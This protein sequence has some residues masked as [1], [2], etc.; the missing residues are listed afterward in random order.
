LITNVRTFVSLFDAVA[1]HH[2]ELFGGAEFMPGKGHCVHVLRR[3][4][5][6][7][8]GGD[9]S[10]ARKT[11]GPCRSRVMDRFDKSHSDGTYRIMRAEHVRWSW[12]AP[13]WPI[14]TTGEL[15]LW[16]FAFLF[17][18]IDVVGY[19]PGLVAYLRNGRSAIDP[20]LPPPL[21]R[22]PLVLTWA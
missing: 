2:G 9:E 10:R 5:P 19:L 16:R 13:P 3:A 21:Q 18:V 22:H 12:C 11:A 4:G 20:D 17:L 14:G 6:D 8:P 1:K 7:H 15:N